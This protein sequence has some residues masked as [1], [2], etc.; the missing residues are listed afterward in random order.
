MLRWLPFLSGGRLAALH[1]I[2]TRRAAPW[3]A[4]G[5]HHRSG[6]PGR[7]R[8]VSTSGQ[9]RR[10]FTCA[11]RDGNFTFHARPNQASVRM[12]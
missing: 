9:D 5:R 8:A 3:T 12:M 2:V 11:T 10:S 6:A 7:S 4:T 1:Q